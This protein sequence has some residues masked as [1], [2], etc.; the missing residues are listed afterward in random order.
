MDGCSCPHVGV[1]AAASCAQLCPQIGG[2]GLHSS[3]PVHALNPRAPLQSPLHVVAPS[4]R[5]RTAGHRG[6]L[7]SHS[8]RTRTTA[9]CCAGAEGPGKPAGPGSGCPVGFAEISP[10]ALCLTPGIPVPPPRSLDFLGTLSALCPLPCLPPLRCAEHT[11]HHCVVRPVG[12]KLVSAARPV[13]TAC[14][15]GTSWLSPEGQGAGLRL[16]AWGSQRTVTR[17][18]VGSASSH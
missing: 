10:R 8:L 6:T 12:P 4:Q 14:H 3:I 15:P 1:T 18:S 17:G 2:R 9:V 5:P 13:S 7:A 11:G 16:P